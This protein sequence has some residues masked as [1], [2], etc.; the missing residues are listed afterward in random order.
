VSVHM[1]A[2]RHERFLAQAIEGVIAQIC[3]FPIELILAE[4]CSPDGTLAIALDYQRR[5]PHL[6]RLITGEKNVGMHANAARSAPAARGKY[7]AF[8][9]GDDFWHHPGKL[10]MQ[11][12]LMTANPNMAF[13]HT[14]F[15]RLTRFRRRSSKHRHRPSQ[16][17]AKGNAYESLLREL[18]VATA[19]SMFR[20]DVIDKFNCSIYRNYDWPFGDYNLELFS[21][22]IGTVGYLDASTATYRK[23]R[24]SACNKDPIVHLKMQL[25]V[26]ECVELFLANYPLGKIKQNEIRASIKSNIYRAAFYAKRSDTM[27]DVYKWRKATGLIGS[28][29]QHKLCMTMVQLDIPVRLLLAGKQFIDLHLSSIR[30]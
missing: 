18:S 14:D 10:Q 20:R 27:E 15:D 2:Y 1:L 13:C 6:I 24:G 25:A 26:E 28:S 5:H 17:L 11:V 22:Q 30:P 12:A 16:W 3:D 4:D 8:C 29:M 7:I 9:E 19:S 23:T 21:S